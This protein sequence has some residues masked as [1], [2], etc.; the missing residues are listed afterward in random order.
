MNGEVK[1]YR[2]N[3]PMGWEEFRRMPDDLR[4]A[5]IKAIRETYNAP[6][7]QI[8]KMMH[9][10]SCSF[11]NEMSR[12]GLRVGCGVRNCNT[13]WDKDGFFAWCAA[14]P[15]TVADEPVEEPVVETVDESV[16]PVESVESVESV[17]EPVIQ[18]AI[19]TTG[20]MTFT[21]NVTQIVETLVNLLGD[22]NVAINIRWNIQGD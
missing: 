19:P 11:S 4:I 6:D 22:A 17:D 13:K 21:G 9:T 5:Y 15:K 14:T 18:R 7:S 3:A 8:A 10:N 16:E 1:S 20:N 12:L 2:L